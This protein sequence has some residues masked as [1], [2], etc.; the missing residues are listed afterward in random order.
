MN[1]AKILRFI[2]FSIIIFAGMPSIIFSA[3]T[4]RVTGRVVDTKTGEP[5]IGANV[6]VEG[7]SMGSATDLSGNYQI[8]NI[9]T[10]SYT[11]VATYIGYQTKKITN[12]K[13]STGKTERLDIVMSSGSL[14]M[15]E[16]VVEVDAKQSGDVYLLTEQRNS[17]NMQDGV[18]AAQ[19][20]RNGDSNAADALTR[21]TGVSVIDGKS[22]YVRGL[23]E[24]YTNTQMN[25]V[26]VPSPDPDK[27]TVPLNLFSSSLLESVTAVKT[28]T[29]D[30]PGVFA[31]G[32]VNIK[33][34]AY[35]DNRV[36][37]LDLGLTQNR[38][39]VS[40]PPFLQGDVGKYD[41]WG[42]DNGLRTIPG[43]V[44]DTVRLGV[45]NSKLNPNPKERKNI[46]GQIGRDFQTGY[47]VRRSTPSK[48]ISLGASYGDKF[49][50]NSNVEYGFFSTL[51]FSN[52]YDFTQSKVR[53]YSMA[54]DSLT[55]AISKTRK[56]SEYSTNL[57]GSFSTG[58]KLWNA[59]KLKF[60]YLYTHT[61]SRG[62][63]DEEG[64]ALNFDNGIFLRQTYSEKSISTAT[65][66]GN[67]RFRFPLDQEINW[68]YTQGLSRLSEPDTKRLNYREKDVPGQDSTYF[69][70]DSYSWSAGTREYL[71]GKDANK[72]L[73]ANYQLSFKDQFNYA[74]KF[75][76]GLRIEQTDRRFQQRSF[77]HSYAGAY[78][79]GFLPA[80]I[81]IAQD[82]QQFGQTFVDS[83][84]FAMDDSGNVDPGLILIES[85]QPS[86]AY[87][88]N[89]NLNAGYAMVEIPLGFGLS[90]GLDKLNFIGGYRLEKYKM[91]LT[92]YDPITGNLFTGNLSGG[93][94]L[95]SNIDE[96]DV[97]PSY[98]LIYHATENSNIRLS[99]SKTIA[100]PEFRE[101]APFEY[102][103]FYGEAS[104]V[105][106]PF[107]KTTKIKNYD[108][109]YEWFPGAG[110]LF[111]VTLFSK[112][113]KNPI[114]LSLIQL[115]DGFYQTPQNAKSAESWG[116][117][118]EIRSKLDFIPRDFGQFEIFFNTTY[119]KTRVHTDSLV[120]LFTGY[121]VKNA[122]TSQNRAL[123]GQSDFI[124]NTSLNYRNLKGLTATIS[125]NTF[126][127]RPSTIGA[128]GLPDIYEYPFHSLNLT[129]NQIF[130]KFKVSLKAKNL[131]NSERK[132]G[133][134]DPHTNE[135]KITN[136]YRP[137]QSI[138]LGITYTM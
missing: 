73:D 109:R 137:G 38:Y 81:T 87:T 10:G 42:Y 119:T 74:Y 27:K 52:D 5:L 84:Y 134:I 86:D 49:N 28:F 50:P 94:T 138:S 132:F 92:P 76:T 53:E 111:A 113:F 133:Q 6:V 14:Q 3:A 75:K 23:G 127:K 57:G 112:T 12:V 122:A 72:N 56:Q 126:T 36:F 8:K 82:R 51:K 88:A 55:S 41:F 89:E 101:I 19:I 15:N 22:V 129:A 26:P 21:V 46:L 105:G 123:Q 104:F 130:G 2:L 61:S 108:A 65:L 18:S 116:S 96:T 13:I 121:Q 80:D 103:E 33:T 39:A 95:L 107:L 98:N 35:P 54:G 9:P 7:T 90:E 34:K 117:E 32:S 71:W 30:L 128:G 43:S 83:N 70:M 106:F 115:A 1:T 11:L 110:E 135:L 93:D 44:P 125:Y 29:P 4:G 66:S 78:S 17:N 40:N 100:R 58:I 91:D 99:Y 67:H 120:T 69:Q 45:Y 62:A 97:L 136:L 37:K 59:H 63:T 79:S 77:Y 25:G 64:R 47:I 85:T 24:R 114:E 60:H 102:R 31:G 118:L 48:P 20:S 124:L 131:L 68:S 16:V